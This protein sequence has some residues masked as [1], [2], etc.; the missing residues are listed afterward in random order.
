MAKVVLVTAAAAAAAAASAAKLAS[1]GT[2]VV[3]RCVPASVGKVVR[4]VVKVAL[5]P[6][7]NVLLV[8]KSVCAVAHVVGKVVL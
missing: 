5:A 1:V 6:I 3:E 8:L 2:A 7:G 4:A